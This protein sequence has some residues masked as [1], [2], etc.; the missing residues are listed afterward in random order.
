MLTIGFVISI[1]S[2]I[3]TYRFEASSCRTS[4]A[5]LI[6]AKKEKSCALSGDRCRRCGDAPA[7][8]VSER[9][10]TAAGAGQTTR[11]TSQVAMTAVSAV[12]VN[13]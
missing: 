2:Y 7:A 9:A 6:A 5:G 4:T 12:K 8:R 3:V 10:C 11:Y 13:G 1:N